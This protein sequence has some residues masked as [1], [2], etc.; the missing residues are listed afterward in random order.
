[1]V[2]KVTKT[3]TS[4][5][6]AM[7]YYL[8]DKGEQTAERVDWTHTLNLA[9]DD[10]EAAWKI[11]AATAQSADQLK[12][13]AGIRAGRKAGSD[14][15]YAYS[16]GWHPDERG[17]ISRAEMV[18]AAKES[19]K[20]IGAA[21]RQAV[22]V[23]HNDADH[24][25]V[26]VIVNRVSPE[27]GKML[28][29]HNDFKK[30]EKWALDYRRE[31]GEELDYC[32]KREA[33]A[34]AAEQTA[35][36]EKVDYVRGDPTVPRWLWNEFQAARDSRIANDNTPRDVVADLRRRDRE[37]HILGKKQAHR[38]KAEWVQLSQTYQERKRLLTETHRPRGKDAIERVKAEMR[39]IW[40][41][42]GQLQTVER[43]EFHERE[44]RLAGIINNAIEAVR[45]A[46]EIDDTSSIGFLGQAFNF[47]FKRE[48]RQN[49][50]EQRQ[51]QDREQLRR[52]HREITGAAL[53]AVDAD[54][55]HDFDQLYKLF[56]AERS[57][58]IDRQQI[59]KA[60]LR[61]KWKIRAVERSKAFEAISP[62]P[63]L[64][65][66]AQGRSKSKIH[67]MDGRPSDAFE[68]QEAEA[69]NDT[70]K[71]ERRGRKRSRPRR[72]RA[73][74]RDGGRSY[75]VSDDE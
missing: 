30:L 54:R 29:R 31:R 56:T 64:D 10:P 1:M 42:L 53:E 12:Q 50:L 44:K 73:N 26:H 8:H 5:K 25:H 49:A 51:A 48:A 19:L 67:D 21:D 43:R 33:K 11:M 65:K 55:A 20:A 18:R 46:R 13:Q 4:F 61:Q 38:H 9:T 14:V 57:S 22:I 28:G 16:L 3:G 52:R 69:A 23:A 66:A 7:A 17:K 45:L 60:A 6:G 40:K 63:S 62:T 71:R 15:V 70:P 37:L 36:G 35:K 59:E 74:G 2:P 39:P 41:D 24:P 47:L 72:Q 32:P 34:Q 58:L 27:N 75:S 68:K